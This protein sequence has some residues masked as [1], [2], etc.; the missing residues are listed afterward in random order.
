MGMRKC[1]IGTRQR[2]LGE[3]FCDSSRDLLSELVELD[4]DGEG[5]TELAQSWLPSVTWLVAGQFGAVR[6]ADPSPYPAGDA[7]VYLPRRKTRSPCHS[8]EGVPPAVDLGSSRPRWTTSN[9]RYA[10]PLSPCPG[11]LSPCPLGS[12]A[13]VRTSCASTVVSRCVETAT[14]TTVPGVYGRSMWMSHPVIGRP[15]AAR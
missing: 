1:P 3:Q 14:P 8:G 7:P 6:R 2:L 11:T 12:P 13:P 5:S 10:M 15:T 9:V 4:F